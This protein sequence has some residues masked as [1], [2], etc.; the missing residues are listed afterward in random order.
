MTNLEKSST[1]EVSNKLNYLRLYNM[2]NDSKY[3]N[4]QIK[5]KSAVYILTVANL[6][7]W[8]LNALIFKMSFG[9]AFIFGILLLVFST[10]QC[11]TLHKCFNS[12]GKAYDTELM[13]SLEMCNIKDINDIKSFKENVETLKKQV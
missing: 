13:M 4:M 7:F 3:R 10:V 5:S 6:A 12:S 2:I 1:L 8:L 11:F 9:G